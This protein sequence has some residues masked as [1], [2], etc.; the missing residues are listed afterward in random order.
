[1]DLD[2]EQSSPDFQEGYKLGRLHCSAQVNRLQQEF[3]VV[4]NELQTTRQMLVDNKELLDRTRQ[5]VL[6]LDLK[7]LRKE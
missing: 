7:R 1:M 5:M 2:F 4:M 3:E 6:D